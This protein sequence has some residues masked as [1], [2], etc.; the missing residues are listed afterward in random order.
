MKIA[1]LYKGKRVQFLEIFF[2]RFFPCGE[3]FMAIFLVSA[4]DDE[5]GSDLFLSVALGSP[6]RSL[7]SLLAVLQNDSFLCN[8]CFESDVD[9]DRASKRA[10]EISNQIVSSYWKV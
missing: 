2:C 9:F 1:S 10:V 5:M 4:L 8:S 3:R 6:P 7:R